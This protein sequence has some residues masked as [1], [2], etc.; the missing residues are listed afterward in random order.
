MASKPPPPSRGKQAAG[1]AAGLVALAALIGVSI[2]DAGN[3]VGD[4]QRHESGGRVYLEAYQDSVGIWTICDGIIRWEDGRPIHRGDSASIDRCR[5]LTASAV[6]NHARPLVRCL[7]QLYGR[8]N[9][10][11]ALVDLSYNVGPAAICSGQ[12]G[13]A[14][15]GGDWA[16]ASR[17]ILLYDRGTFPRPHPGAD[18]R[19]TARGWACRIGGLSNRRREN[20]VR[21]DIARPAQGAR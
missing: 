9:Q 6:V 12:I 18:C 4:I 3:V 17:A 21:F 5:A 8:T 14:I 20:A 1:A 15:R 2:T 7:P 19:R 13:T 16:G 10:V 11:R